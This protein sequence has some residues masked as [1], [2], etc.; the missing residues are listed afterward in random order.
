MRPE[1]GPVDRFQHRA[2]DSAGGVYGRGVVRYECAIY[3]YFM[4]ATSDSLRKNFPHFEK[5]IAIHC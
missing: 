2:R 5:M 3:V 4:F 1:N